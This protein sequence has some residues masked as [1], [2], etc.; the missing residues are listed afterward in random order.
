MVYNNSIAANRQYTFQSDY[1]HPLKNNQK[2]ESGVKAIIRRASSDFES[3]IRKNAEPD[4]KINPANTN[5]FN[6]DQDILSVYSSYSFKWKKT[7]VRL[8]AR[9]EQTTIEGD[10]RSSD[11]KVSQD[12][13]TFLPNIQ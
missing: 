9:V 5:N 2:L 12:Y 8:G 7:N 4:Y 1:V 13:F 3:L 10:F 11:L 6:Y